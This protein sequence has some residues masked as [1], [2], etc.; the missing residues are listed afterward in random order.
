MIGI[1][2]Q[3]PLPLR[4]IVFLAQYAEAK[5]LD[6]AWTT[7]YRRDAAVAMGVLAAG[8]ERMTIG[9]S[10]LPIF[11]RSPAVLAMTA[12]A[13]AE[14]APDRV[15]VGLGSSTSVI[16][17]E[18]HGC[19][20]K[21]PLERLES[22]SELIRAILGGDTTAFD[23]A[24]VASR[25]FRLEWD[26]L[27]AAVPIYIAALGEKAITRAAR[28]AD[29]LLLNA[30]P[31]TH[32]PAIRAAADA[33]AAEAGRQR[34]SLAGDVRVA[35]G[36]G[37]RISRIRER[38]RKAMASYARV[39]QYR[40]FFAG[41]GFPAEAAAIASAWQ[42]HDQEAAVAAMTNPMLDSMVA[43]GDEDTVK[44]QLLAFLEAGL[45]HVLVYPLWDREESPADAIRHIVTVV[46]EL[47]GST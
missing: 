36:S 1:K 7:E 40:R 38:Q 33:A 10:I 44:A 3:A 37:E 5:G 27:T 6:S 30:T 47:V 8:T 19:Q 45:D 22:Y 23:R 26:G 41:A 32:L 43:I 25:G 14:L 15:I 18:W 28:Y 13:V 35:I 24:G 21:E 2:F 17:E 11:T 9:S 39:P 42:Q 16:V 12:A 46:S 20:R 34:I 31:R 29:G 4:E